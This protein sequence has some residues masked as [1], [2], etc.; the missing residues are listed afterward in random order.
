MKFEKISFSPKNNGS[1]KETEGFKKKEVLIKEK[2]E[3]VTNTLKRNSPA[4]GSFFLF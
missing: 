3:G 2:K 4:Q 1:K